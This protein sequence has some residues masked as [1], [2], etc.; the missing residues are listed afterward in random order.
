MKTYYKVEN[1]TI[2]DWKIV[3]V[4][5][6]TDNCFNTFMK[7]KMDLI[8]TFKSAIQAEKEALKDIKKLKKAK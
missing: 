7:A 5:T 2:D 8:D 6:F 1:N 3:K 4:N